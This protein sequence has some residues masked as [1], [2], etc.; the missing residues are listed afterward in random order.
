MIYALLVLYGDCP[1]LIDGLSLL[2]GKRFSDEMPKTNQL[3]PTKFSSN[4]KDDPL[5]G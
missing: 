5:S 1:P 2:E 3:Q 4:H